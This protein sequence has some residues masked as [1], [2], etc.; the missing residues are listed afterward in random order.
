MNFRLL[1]A[2]LLAL[3]AAA[4]T[5]QTRTFD[6]NV[7]NDT[8]QPITV[9]LTKDGPPPEDGWLSP[10]QLA[11]INPVESEVIAG[12]VVPPGKTASTG[13][14]TG[15]FEGETMAWLRVYIGSPTFT[16]M[17]AISR[18]SVNRLDI[19]LDIGKNDIVITDRTG[20]VTAERADNQPPA[21]PKK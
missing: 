11:E 10:E 2:L 3:V 4:C 17:L 19:L 9:W 1:P 13:P 15:K 6:V 12:Q 7:R 16:Q 8:S 18:R 14:R 21:N 5:S 20:R